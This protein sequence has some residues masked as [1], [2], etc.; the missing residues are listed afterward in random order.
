MT[1]LKAVLWD[2]GGVITSS[3][4]DA[5]NRFEREHGI[6]RNFIRTVNA[7]DPDTNAWARFERSQISVEEFD[8]MFENEGRALGHAVRGRDV[9]QLLGGDLRPRMVEALKRCSRVF[10]T[11]CLTNNVRS[12]QGPG[13]MRDNARAKPMQNVMDLFD[14]VIESSRE[15]IRKP[16]PAFYQLACERLAIEP[17]EA[18]F[19]DDLGVNLKPARAMGMFTIKVV[20]EDQALEDLAEVTGLELVG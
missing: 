17:A 8:R 14:L 1:Q 16:S 19:L 5:F 10:K 18:V 3:P 15:G 9:L 11:A 4:F 12:G 20:S 13:M 6:P 7:T 2:F